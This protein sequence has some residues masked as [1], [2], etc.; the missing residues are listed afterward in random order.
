LILIFHAFAREVGPLRKRLERTARIGHGQVR[1]LSAE[2]GGRELA[3]IATGIGP[4][5]AREVARH[6][7]ELFPQPAIAIATGV[8]GGLLPELAIAD[9]VLADR[10]LFA[11]SGAAHSV[12]EH[13]IA[14]GHLD[15]V[16]QALRQ[17]R[18][19]FSTGALF[20]SPHALATGHEKR[21]AGELSG[22]IAVDMETAAIAIEAAERGVPFVAL[23][24]ISDTAGEDLPRVP[25]LDKEGRVRTGRLAA[26]LLTHPR[27]A[28]KI[29]AMARNLS[30]ATQALA[31]ALEAIARGIDVQRPAD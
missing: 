8:A 7:F 6:A 19:A 23:R 4:A 14:G 12:R 2:L 10:L 1:G 11:D 27:D 26:H 31:D 22:A 15:A 18:V 20:T 29:P 28:L 21:R 5:R 13:V 9:L 24:A 17:A 3:L 25:M 16:A 30:R